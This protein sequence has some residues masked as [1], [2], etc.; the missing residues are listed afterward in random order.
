MNK[1]GIAISVNSPNVVHL[2]TFLSS[3]Q[4][5]LKRTMKSNKNKTIITD[6]A[7]VSAVTFKNSKGVPTKSAVV[8]KVSPRNIKIN[9]LFIVVFCSLCCVSLATNNQIYESFVK[10][11]FLVNFTCMLNIKCFLCIL[12]F[13]FRIEM[14]R[15]YCA[16]FL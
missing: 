16:L 3:R 6:V 5:C 10:K 12:C 13:A 4:I 1:Y 9:F 2:Y 15:I 11:H 8:K 7:I 14:V